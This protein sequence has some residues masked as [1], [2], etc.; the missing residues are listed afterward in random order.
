MS[1]TI[2]QRAVEMQFDNKEFENNAQGSIRTL[3]ALKK[4]LNL[5]GA[6]KG[7]NDITLAGKSFTLDHIAQGVDALA[8]R[9]STM[10]IIGMT[11][12]QNLTNSA[13]EAGKKMLDNLIINPAKMGF[14]EYETQI[15][16]IQTVLANT[17]SKG[18]TLEQVNAALDEL[19]NYSDKT[20]YNFTEM[21]RNIGTFTAAGVSLDTATSA[22][23]GIANLAAVSGSNA[24]QA[25]TAMYQLSQAMASGTVKLMDWNSVV[26]AGMGGQVFQDA[27]KE[28]ARAHGISIDAMIAKEGSFRETLQL[29]WL[30]S[31]VLT[32]TL[33]KFTGDLTESQLKTMGYTEEQIAGIVKL[34]Q[35][36]NDAATKV[37]TFSQLKDTL[38]EAMQS[39]WSQS[40]RIIVGDFEQARSLF[41]S[42]SD[43]I[44]VLIKGSS[45]ARNKVL[46]SWADLGGRTVLVESIRNVFE[47]LLS[48]MKPI[49]EAFASVFPPATGFALYKLSIGLFQ[50]TEK[51]KISGETADQLKRI[52]TGV[53]TI[54]KII[55]KGASL[56]AEGVGTLFGKLN[57][58]GGG[59]LEFLA[60][61]GD[62]IVGIQDSIYSL[63][64][65]KKI[66]AVVI[67]FLTNFGSQAKLAFYNFVESLKTSE[68]VE[69]ILLDIKDALSTLGFYLDMVFDAIMKKLGPF[70]DAFLNTFYGLLSFLSPI[71][72]LIKTIFLNILKSF[73]TTK[74]GKT[75]GFLT[76]I[77]A[78]F[79]P[80]QEL[81]KILPKIIE[82]IK[83]KLVDLAPIFKNLGQAA[84]EGL[85]QLGKIVSDALKTINFD[86]VIS[87]LT[88]GVFVGMFL[89]IRKAFKTG[90]GILDGVKGTFDGIAGT[91]TSVQNSLKMW[92]Q[93]VKADMITKIAIAVGLLAVSLFLLS[94]I[95]GAKLAV[96]MITMA[97]LFK[98]LLATMTAFEKI[99]GSS[100]FASMGKIVVGLL[101]MAAAILILTG[102]MYLLSLLDT[103]EI[104]RGIV[105]ISALSFALVQS[106]KALSQVQGLDAK[107]AG[108]LILFG[109]GLLVMSAALKVLSTIDMNGL[110]T[111]MV[112]FLGILTGVS[113][114]LKYAQI[115][116]AS[117]EKSVGLILL[118]GALYVMALALKKMTEID[119]EQLLKGLG[120]MGAILLELAVFLRIAGDPKN[121]IATAIGLAILAG[122]LIL[123]LF[124]LRQMAALDPKVF[125]DGAKRMGIALAGLGVFLRL[126]PK[127]TLVKSVGIA[128]L[129]GALYLLTGVLGLLGE[130]DP[131]KITQGM[132]TIAVA[133]GIMSIALIAMKESLLGAV[134][135]TVVVGALWLLVPVI[136]ALGSLPI[137][138]IG[139]ALGALVA[140][141]VILGL[142]G[143]VLGPVVP[144]I[145]T[146]SAAILLLGASVAMI[147]GGI[148]LFSLGLASLVAT[149]YALGP[150]LP[151]LATNFTNL[152]K[153]MAKGFSDA[154]PEML[155]AFVDLLL[156]LIEGFVIVIPALIEGILTIIGALLSALAEHMPEFVES[157]WQILLAMIQGLRDHIGELTTLGVEI[158]DEM[159]ASLTAKLPEMIQTGWD[160]VIALIDGWTTS[161]DENLPTLMTSLGA[162]GGEIV[163]GLVEGIVGGFGSFGQAFTDLIDAGVKTFKEGLGI[164]S[165]ST[166]FFG[167]GD[168]VV[169]GLIDGIGSKVQALITKVQTMVQDMIKKVREHLGKF[170]QAGKDLIQQLIEGVA[171]KISALVS[172]ANEAVQKARDEVEAWK[173]RFYDAGVKLIQGLIDGIGDMIW[174]AVTKARSLA[175]QVIDA[176]R[177]ILKMESPSRVAHEIGVYLVEG[178][179]NG[180]SD[181]SNLAAISAKDMAAN[182]VNAVNDAVS[183]ISAVI[184]SDM[185]AEPVIRPVVDLTDVVSG[186]EEIN[187][188][189]GS[190][191]FGISPRALVLAGDISSGLSGKT[192]VETTDLSPVSKKDANI[193]FTQNN[194][195][196][197]ALS[198]LEIYRQTRNQLAAL[199]GLVG[200]T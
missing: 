5:E 118:G 56:L 153:A 65:Y 121:M 36:A 107:T 64:T 150:V 164:E 59:I 141:F 41:T 47:G 182:T 165:P 77:L 155:K 175:Q 34:G 38:K 21:T 137:E 18:T 25:S 26:N 22:I 66:L 147:G 86:D 135:L 99:A 180:I 35:M 132:I 28:T 29:G 37:K 96:A 176:I 170:W 130:M 177:D 105:A 40:W 98:E 190:S 108:S 106:T 167:F 84:K 103:Q 194:Y 78:D 39:G 3:D 55:F 127:D 129:A 51:M 91:L 172:K 166:V 115:D 19:N 124:P 173:Q 142:A 187:K 157:G 2:E 196:P 111:G 70:G 82:S 181:T 62:F 94:K 61:I 125:E 71:P 146:L 74:T 126:I 140:F 32:E 158:V 75:T 87:V 156:M 9:F 163:A 116:K 43:T 6:S 17:S 100:N 97:V 76:G 58:T 72:E 195:S 185:N 112:A 148:F 189:L 83:K 136:A 200:N 44:G 183:R 85:G 57:V 101:A 102:A 152:L 60:T 123:L 191:S 1:K 113:E 16:A 159:I 14:S 4:A 198:R 160:F 49:Q 128:V 178:F 52:F 138:T 144:V 199:K 79:T 145:V 95:D 131:N 139:I 179:A 161:V 93:N 114:F 15:N 171:N 174:A 20:I 186:S 92:Q 67:E 110:V 48:I 122:S 192:E 133:L 10:G 73:E 45:D 12:I 109:L 50:L 53:A 168:N 90:G 151:T 24:Q 119:N 23:K 7:L 31:E 184:N 54:F 68:G 149:L 162:L 188:M 27:L 80:L 154:A 13:I 117:M 134:A 30:S 120:I 81:G 33:S 63:D 46:Q 169:Q 8:N 42:I 69:A 11:V 88:T 197:T 143:L 89:E 104:L 193:S